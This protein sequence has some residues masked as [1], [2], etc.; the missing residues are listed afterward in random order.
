MDLHI[1]YSNL[2]A[3]GGKVPRER[4]AFF[5]FY[6]RATMPSGGPGSPSLNVPSTVALD[7]TVITVSPRYSLGKKSPDYLEW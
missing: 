2:P 6:I 5:L 7:L 4:D 3:D 1:Y